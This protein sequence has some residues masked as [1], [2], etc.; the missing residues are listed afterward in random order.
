VDQGRVDDAEDTGLWRYFAYSEGSRRG[1][2][3]STVSEGRDAVT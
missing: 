2:F 1:I 3:A